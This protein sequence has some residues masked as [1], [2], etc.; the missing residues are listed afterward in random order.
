M[1]PV[2][3]K[4]SISGYNSSNYQLA[5]VK[6]ADGNWTICLEG[7]PVDFPSAWKTQLKSTSYM[8]TTVTYTDLTSIKFVASIP[9]GYTKIGKLST[10][11][12]V[13]QGSSTQIAFVRKKIY[14]PSNS[15]GLLGSMRKLTSIDFETFDTSKAT[16]MSYFLR[17]SD[18]LRTADVSK[19]DTSKVTNMSYMFADCYVLSDIDVSKFDTSKV[20]NMSSMFYKCSKLSSLNV[21]NFNTS[22]GTTMSG[23]F[24]DCS[25]LFG[26]DVSGFNTSNVTSFS[27]MFSDCSR[28]TSVDV[29]NFNTSK[30][31]KM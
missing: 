22:K 15:S 6:D 14:A 26:L 12:E 19:F 9:N 21:D 30:G 27:G 5:T 18:S 4:F 31:T 29:S 3:S 25:S 16:S 24:S 1:Q 17:L 28:L 7:K 11:L 8:T 20:T 10:G 2:L 13:Y 23:M